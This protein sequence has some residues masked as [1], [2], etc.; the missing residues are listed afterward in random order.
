MEELFKEISIEE[1]CTYDVE[2]VR[3]YSP[4]MM[5]PFVRK[6]D[7]KELSSL[8]MAINHRNHR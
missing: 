8:Q 6:V 5:S 2:Y 1:N 4:F 7:G 3:S